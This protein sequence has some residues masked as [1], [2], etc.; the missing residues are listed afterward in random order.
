M[1]IRRK[2]PKNG[3]EQK[4]KTLVKKARNAAIET[5]CLNPKIGAPVQI[6]KAGRALA[7]TSAAANSYSKAINNQVKRKIR[8][9]LK[10]V[11]ELGRRLGL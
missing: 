10:P 9:T 4:R 11:N 7:E 3:I 5:A 2:T 1:A 6:Y 8:R